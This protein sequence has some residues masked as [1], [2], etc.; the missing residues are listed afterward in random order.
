M[1]FDDAAN[2]LHKAKTSIR[3]AAAKVGSGHA[4]P[5]P[6]LP[7][8]PTALV[9]GA[10]A[11][12]RKCAIVLA[13][14][15]FE[16][17]LLCGTNLRRSDVEIPDLSSLNVLVGS[18]L[19]DMRGSV[20]NFGA[21]IA[22]RGRKREYPVGAVVIDGEAWNAEQLDT[23]GQ[24]MG[25]PP[26]ANWTAAVP[27]LGQFAPETKLP[28]G[29]LCPSAAAGDAILL[30]SAAAGKAAAFLSRGKLTPAPGV[31]AVRE[32]QCRGCGDCVAACPFYAI[33]LQERAVGVGVA[34][35]NQA[36]CRGCGLCVPSCQ[37]RAIE[38]GDA[39]P[40]MER[41]LVALVLGGDI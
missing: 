21:I 16:T 3:V 40:G 14:I 32:A 22:H 36:L 27:A 39:P 5:P 31:V 38:P 10:G 12:G 18:E 29:F 4:S 26:G 17:T 2:A 37:T 23:L 13:T 41:A 6:E 20:G 9:L 19:V 7:I 25:A 11:S 8:C 34:H 30:G 33:G 28:G 35:V 15:G 24:M 1:H